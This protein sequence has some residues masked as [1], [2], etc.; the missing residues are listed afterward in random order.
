MSELK[1]EQVST[2]FM[3]NP[4]AT[5][6]SIVRF[7]PILEVRTNTNSGTTANT[8]K[9]YKK[10]YHER[11]PNPRKLNTVRAIASCDHCLKTSSRC[12]ILQKRYIPT[13]LFPSQ[14]YL[15]NELCTKFPRSWLS[16]SWISKSITLRD[17]STL[18]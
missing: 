18:Q 15:K 6:M 16:F 5:H 1:V 13:F 14:C 17:C 12:N 8:R 9:D 7:T 3:W 2:I 10:T 4:T 11:D